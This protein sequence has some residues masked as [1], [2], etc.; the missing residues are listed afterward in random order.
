MDDFDRPLTESGDLLEGV[1]VGEGKTLEDSAGYCAGAIRRV[2]TG[3]AAECADRCRHIRGREKV[4]IVR[5]QDRARTALT[6]EGDHAGII[7]FAPYLLQQPQTHDVSAKK[8]T[9]ERQLVA[10]SRGACFR[11][12]RL[13]RCPDHGPCSAGN[14]T[15]LLAGAGHPATAE[16]VSC[17]HGANTGI[18]HSLPIRL[19]GRRNGGI[20]VRER[21]SAASISSHHVPEMASYNCVLTALVG[22][23]VFSPV[24]NQASRSGIM[25]NVA[26]VA[27][28]GLDR[29]RIDNNWHAVWMRVRPI[30]V[31][32]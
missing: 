20:I 23:A 31:V 13:H 19:P 8:S 15:P 18:P 17:V 29:M 11:Y 26:A 28:T 22:S 4:G 24:R 9:V 1:P 2:L 5:I 27:S 16:A 32:R 7:R 12:H 30:P 3:A 14:K 6:R 10:Q 25:R 21:F